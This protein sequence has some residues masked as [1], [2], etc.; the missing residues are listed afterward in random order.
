MERAEWKAKACRKTQNHNNNINNKNHPN[1]PFTMEELSTMSV[2]AR[3]I[4]KSNSFSVDDT[5]EEVRVA[6]GMRKSVSFNSVAEVCRVDKLSYP[7]DFFY[8]QSE[9]DQ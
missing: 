3:A 1:N 6:G 8:T 4:R 2:K 9:T 5:S 7:S